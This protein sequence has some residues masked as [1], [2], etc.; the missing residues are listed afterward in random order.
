MD[1]DA[2]PTTRA[3]PPKEPISPTAIV[4]ADMAEDILR[5]FE[6]RFHGQ[7]SWT[8]DM[9]GMLTVDE[10]S[11]RHERVLLELVVHAYAERVRDY[12]MAEVHKM[13][14]AEQLEDEVRRKMEIPFYQKSLDTMVRAFEEQVSGKK[15]V[16]AD[17]P[18]TQ[19]QISLDTKRLLAA[20]G[21]ETEAQPLAQPDSLEPAPAAEEGAPSGSDKVATTRPTDDSGSA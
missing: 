6:E 4:L 21:V 3:P 14:R 13:H 10:A 12:F 1:S 7:I 11:S 8:I 16:H 19:Q 15:A 20:L 2:D 18:K 17:D 5:A 9:P